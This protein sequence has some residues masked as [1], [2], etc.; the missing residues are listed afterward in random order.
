M[1]DQ[2][3]ASVGG[4]GDGS[5]TALAG[6]NGGSSESGVQSQESGV[7]TGGES[8]TSTDPLA[9]LKGF[10]ETQ[11][12]TGN[13]VDNSGSENGDQTAVAG[14]ESGVE[15]TTGDG[16]QA[17]GDEATEEQPA[18]TGTEGEQTGDEPAGETG[19]ETTEDVEGSADF[20]A[21][22]SEPG[23]I[24]DTFEAVKAKFPRNSPTELV[25]EMARYG[26][27]AK[28]GQE[29]INAI[30]G[31]AFVP[32]MTK[33]SESL[34]AGDPVQTFQ[35][36]G[37][38]AGLDQMVKMMGEAIYIGIAQHEIM[39][40]NPQQKP[41][42]DALTG[43]IDFSLKERF[44]PEMSLDKMAKLADWDAAGWFDKIEKAVSEDYFD[45]AE[46]RESLEASKN[47]A[48]LKTIKAN[49]ELKRQLEE[50]KSK[51]DTPANAAGNT[52]QVDSSF[53]TLATDSIG[54]TFGEV[55]LK[56]SIL[57]DIDT[58]TPE[59]KEEKA[60]LR[61]TLTTAAIAKFRASDEYKKLVEDNRNGKRD[62]AA[63]RD[64]LTTALNTAIL[65]TKTQTTTA[66]RLLASKL[67][68]TAKRQSRPEGQSSISYSDRTVASTYAGRYIGSGFAADR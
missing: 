57:R 10:F 26:E 21:L 45:E 12:T 35:N 55:V 8:T 27:I 20:D 66:E 40:A 61:N 67:G 18:E 6:S 65:E 14:Q 51:A 49:Q 48:L 16:D 50:K 25:K 59:I 56:N 62:T 37:E 2:T 47:P 46:W 17:T 38:T 34:R 58:D 30:G 39:Q 3:N 22:S 44:G 9:R 36:I 23:E 13:Q 29:V 60:L 11:E 43:M 4:P 15:E 24:L 54:K 33:I 7:G 19:S 41:L 64:K 1:S 68:K 42:S 52:A 53:D 63:F 32:G 28:K 5:T 31:E